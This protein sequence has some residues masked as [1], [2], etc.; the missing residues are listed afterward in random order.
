[1]LWKV[2]GK[3]GTE[4]SSPNGVLPILSPTVFQRGSVPQSHC[5]RAGSSQRLSISSGH[6]LRGLG[7]AADPRPHLPQSDKGSP[8]TPACIATCSGMGQCRRLSITEA[9][10]TYT[11]AWWCWE[12]K[13]S[14]TLGACAQWTHWAGCPWMGM[15]RGRGLGA[16]LRFFRGWA[17]PG[18]GIY[19]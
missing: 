6:C 7:R 14:T 12:K 9:L 13:T 11:P 16:Q 3:P 4:N 19:Q 1:M 17:G 5:G 15:E 2:L 8:L 10:A 18:S